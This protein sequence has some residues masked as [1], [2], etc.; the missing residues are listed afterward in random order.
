FALSTSWNAARAQNANNLLF[1]IKRL[2]IKELELSFNLDSS[3]VAELRKLIPDNGFKVVSLH[4]FCPTPEGLS[5][6]DA[7]PDCYSMSSLDSQERAL[8]LKYTCR[9]IDTA[10]SLGAKAVVLH[11][12]RVEMHDKTRELIAL[13]NQEF[14]NTGRYQDLKLEFL[15][16]RATLFQPFLD[17]T[18][19][20]LRQLNQYAEDQGIYL[21]LENRFYYR[22]IPSL[23]EIGIILNE[24]KGGNI[25]Y[26][27]DTGHAQLMENLGIAQHKDY[28]DL[29]AKD[30]LGIHLH[31]ITGCLDHQAP[32][33]G[34]FDFAS[35]RPYL[36][37]ETLR[38]IE[39][40]YPATG[41]EIKKSVT[42]L[43]KIFDGVFYNRQACS[44]GKV[45]P[46]FTTRD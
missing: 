24:F 14:T 22:E 15:R 39:A 32:I 13:Y 23:Q 7:L 25:F 33:K 36:K 40:H 38:V 4:N 5:Q 1:E 37:K 45:L 29:Y 21:G 31:N 18:L 26:W 42:F 6:E 34:E 12:G 19:L 41:D 30:M 20:S 35:L 10:K 27:H 43:T 3:I 9:T 44:F 11:C 2:G 8:S 28:L 46:F 17:N 16:E